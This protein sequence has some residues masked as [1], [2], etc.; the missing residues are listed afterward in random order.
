MALLAATALA[1]AG[2]AAF[3][4]VPPSNLGSIAVGAERGEV[5]RVLGRPL[6]E[7][8]L[9]CGQLA[10]YA[11]DRGRKPLRSQLDVAGLHPLAPLLAGLVSHP[12]LMAGQRGELL[13]V[14]APNGGVLSYALRR[15]ADWARASAENGLILDRPTPE[16]LAERYYRAAVASPPGATAF[17]CH[18]YAAHLGHSEARLAMARAYAEGLPPVRADRATALALALLAA[19]D[20]SAD[21][22][23]YAQ[24]LAAEMTA[25]ERA[26]A[27]AK[28]N[29]WQPDV[30]SCRL[31]RAVDVATPSSTRP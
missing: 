11:F 10:V 25:D 21:A 15:E 12:F 17:G 5:E 13:I 18:C 28:A 14:Y 16:E 26:A 3:R 9:A 20:G 19:G 7:H 30:A 6:A 29:R 8:S 22:A 1:A 31:A 23:A 4:G 27:R 24:A 2:C